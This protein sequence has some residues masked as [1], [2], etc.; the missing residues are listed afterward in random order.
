M[1]F[2]FVSAVTIETNSAKL[3]RFRHRS[4]KKCHYK[5]LHIN[6]YD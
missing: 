5:Y 3:L 6:L 2:C 4:H 1:S